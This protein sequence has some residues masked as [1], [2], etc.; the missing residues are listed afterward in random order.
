MVQ[1]QKIILKQS[2]IFSYLW[3]PFISIFNIQPCLLPVAYWRFEMYL[4]IK[5][6]YNLISNCLVYLC[7]VSFNALFLNTQMQMG[8]NIKLRSYYYSFLFDIVAKHFCISKTYIFIPIYLNCLQFLGSRGWMSQH[9]ECGF[10]SH[11]VWIYF[12]VW[13]IY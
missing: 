12:L 10:S 7:P 1:L 5:I 6:R 8:K 13:K 3:S 2:F 9:I 4:K 11:A